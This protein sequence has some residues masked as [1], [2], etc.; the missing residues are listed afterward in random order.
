MIPLIRSYNELMAITQL[1]DEFSQKIDFKKSSGHLNKDVERISSSFAAKTVVNLPVLPKFSRKR[2]T[3]SK[4]AVS[5]FFDKLD[6]NNQIQ[7]SYELTLIERQKSYVD[8]D[9]A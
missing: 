2:W 5:K 6:Y 1:K 9:A 4:Q 3:K 7:S 8:Q